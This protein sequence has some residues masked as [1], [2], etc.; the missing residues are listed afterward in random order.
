M[1]A[2][3]RIATGFMTVAKSPVT[4][5]EVTL[6]G[7]TVADLRKQFEWVTNAEMDLSKVWH[8]SL[9]GIERLGGALTESTPR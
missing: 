3:P 8:V 6:F 5:L 1:S 7:R 4:A 9:H 2:T